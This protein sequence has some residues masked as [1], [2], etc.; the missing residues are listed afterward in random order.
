MVG[1]ALF[2]ATAGCTFI[3]F[4]AF[5]VHG[6]RLTSNSVGRLIKPRIPAWLRDKLKIIFDASRQYH[7]L[8]VGTL[9]WLLLLSVLIHWI[10]TVAFAFL[11]WS[12]G[13]HLAL[14]EFGWI[15]SCWLLL[16]MLPI[17]IAGLG[18][19]EGS[20]LYFMGPYG[21]GGPQIIALAC[22]RLATSLTIAAIG[23]LLEL[24]YLR[25]R[26]KA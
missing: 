6:S 8:K 17:T 15:R 24:R 1:S 12:L 9:A 3:Y 16:A 13:M 5:H 4:L 18:M 20:L 22:L 23:G 26:R 7:D 25:W 10:T 2:A 14:I 19:R 11:G 21:V